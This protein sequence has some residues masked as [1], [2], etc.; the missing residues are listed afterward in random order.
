MAARQ[1]NSKQEIS[2]FPFLA[3]LV[4][5]MGSL[6]FLLLLTSTRGYANAAAR[7]KLVPLQPKIVAVEAPRAE[8]PK[9]ITI[10]P[11]AG[12]LIF[13]SAD[14][15]PEPE[16]EVPSVDLVALAREQNAALEAAWT[17]K[18]D[19]LNEQREARLRLLLQRRLLAD[20]AGKK[21]SELQDEI[22]RLEAELAAAGKKF[23]STKALV[24]TP[25]DQRLIEQQIAVLRERLKDVKDQAKGGGKHAV[26]PVDPISGTSRRPILIECTGDGLKFLQE[27][28]E[29]TADDLKGY[30]ERLNP[31]LAGTAALVNY[32]IDHDRQAAKGKSISEPYVLLLVR[33]SGTVGYYVAMQLLSPLKTQHGYELIEEDTKLQIPQLDTDAREACQGAI[34]RLMTQRDSIVGSTNR[35]GTGGPGGRGGPGGLGG[36]SVVNPNRSSQG[37]GFQVDDV[38]GDR[39]QS[40]VGSHSWEDV[41]KFR[42]RENRGGRPG[43][44]SGPG[45]SGAGASQQTVQF[46]GSRGGGTGGGGGSNGTGAGEGSDPADAPPAA[47]GTGG[48]GPTLGRNDPGTQTANEILDQIERGEFPGPG[49]G[50]GNV[51]GDGTGAEAGTGT[52]TGPAG[53]GAPF[54]NEFGGGTGSIA[55]ESSGDNPGAAGAGSTPGGQPGQPGM[56]PG[57]GAQPGTGQAPAGIRVTREPQLLDPSAE[58]AN[59]SGPGGS[60]QGNSGR[61][62]ENVDSFGG[63]ENRGGAPGRFKG[64]ATGGKITDIPSSGGRELSPAEAAL[65]EQPARGPSLGRNEQMRRP[66]DDVPLDQLSKRHWGQSDP[67]A[68][69]TMEREVSIHVAAETIKIG[70]RTLHVGRGE[71]PIQ[72]FAA[73]LQGVEEEIQSWGR[74]PRGFYFRP[75][76]LFVISPGG[77]QHVDRLDSLL[78]ESQLTVSRKLSFDEPA[79]GAGRVS[80]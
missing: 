21:V 6:I 61:S 80:P 69:I 77:N 49:S 36:G 2:L 40:N 66:G 54:D 3:V 15:P 20:S 10:N 44:A 76:L 11:E 78:K 60:E 62:W 43:V 14:L 12:L 25:A 38:L 56:L 67:S 16:P 37:G 7:A 23:D 47:N 68:T 13:E 34:N 1:K 55:G 33:P 65:V 22:A 45:G 42:G 50:I 32:W 41:E 30:P 70:K 74:P 9:R 29:L 46:S 58:F 17:H 75:S 57:T 28:I 19:E 63:R 26:L 31:L 73:I 24:L 59:P 35:G 4:C 5:V 72:L 8:A 52:D 48:R 71:S 27:D 39:D 79:S 53:A 18:V 64:E 51:S